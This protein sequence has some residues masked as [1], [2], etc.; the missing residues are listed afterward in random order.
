[1]HRK[2]PRNREIQYKQSSLK[3]SVQ[4]INFQVYQDKKKKR[5]KTQITDVRNE[6]GEIATDP[7]DIKRI[8]RKYYGK[9]YSIKFHN[10]DEM[11]RFLE[12]QNS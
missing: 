5:E 11:N 8:K 9:L 2:R 6:R 1:M 10:S 3:S 4:L 12:R 7:M